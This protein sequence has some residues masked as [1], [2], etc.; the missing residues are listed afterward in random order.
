MLL[1]KFF[2]KN[3]YR[4]DI[5]FR[6]VCKTRSRIRQVLI[7]NEKTSTKDVLGIDIDT[8]KKWSEFQFTPDMN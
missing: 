8:Y 5:N 7:G 1:Q 2:L 6:L 4:K 3:S